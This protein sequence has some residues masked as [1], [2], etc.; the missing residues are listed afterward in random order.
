MKSNYKKCSGCGSFLH[1]NEFNKG[2]F[3][4]GKC[5]ACV[6]KYNKAYRQKNLLKLR[7]REKELRFEKKVKALSKLDI[8]GIPKCDIC[9]FKDN[10]RLLQVDHINN[11]GS[12]DL[13]NHGIRRKSNTVYQKILG[14]DVKDARMKYR[15]LCVFHNWARRYGKTAEQYKVIVLKDD[16]HAD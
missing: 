4:K 2:Y 14:M 12:A 6:N 7:I 15:I 3:A 11:D 10:I 13:T 1:R 8:N 5:K 16:N 9:G